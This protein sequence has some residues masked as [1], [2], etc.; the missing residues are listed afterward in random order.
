LPH[1]W[2]FCLGWEGV[3][4]VVVVMVVGVFLSQWW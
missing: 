4:V 2:T 3:V 1:V